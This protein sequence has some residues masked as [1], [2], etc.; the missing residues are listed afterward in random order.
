M[1]SRAPVTLWLEQWATGDESVAEP[2]FEIIYPELSQFG[3]AAA[4][5]RTSGIRT[6]CHP[7][8]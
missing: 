6:A 2:L 7:G 1:A 3:L 5:R 8:E 4:A